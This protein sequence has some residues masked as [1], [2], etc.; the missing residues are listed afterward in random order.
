MYAL[1]ISI[2]GLVVSIVSVCSAMYFS[3]RNSKHTDVKEIEERVRQN[4][5]MNLKLDEID[6]KVTN[7][8]SDGTITKQ[9]LQQLTERV[10]SVESSAKQAH[11]RIDRVEKVLDVKRDEDVSEIGQKE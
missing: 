10:V 5:T 6:R 2:C 1:I 8:Q 7:I 4:T 3:S 9:T 11:H